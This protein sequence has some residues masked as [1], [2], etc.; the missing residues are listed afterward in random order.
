MKRLMA[1]ALAAL[2]MSVAQA[3]PWNRA[4]PT[5]AP[6]SPA[7]VA[8]EGLGRLLDYLQRGDGDP[9]RLSAFLERTVAPYFDFDY[10][11]RAAAGNLYRRLDDQQ[12]RQLTQHIKRQFLTALTRRLG[13]Y[14]QQRVRVVSQRL[15]RDGRTGVVTT[16]I[17]NPNGYPSRLDF[18]FYRAAEGWKVYDVMANGQSAVVHYRRQ[19][20]RQWGYHPASALRP[21]P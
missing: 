12:R 9:Q 4:A 11:A 19:L 15:A 1:L 18:R 7:A 8:Q 3:Q 13:H 10:M 21:Q 2:L 14:G 6:D 16:A 17:Q 20:R 5:F